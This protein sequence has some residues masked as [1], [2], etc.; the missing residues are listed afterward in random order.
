M[1]W[2]CQS[3]ENQGWIWGTRPGCFIL[4]R[5]HKYTC[6]DMRKVGIERANDN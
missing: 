6:P 4:Y 5:L 2:L 3:F 1:N